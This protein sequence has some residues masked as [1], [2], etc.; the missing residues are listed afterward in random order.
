[1]NQNVSKLQS[2]LKHF[3]LHQEISYCFA[4]GSGVFEQNLASS[5]KLNQNNRIQNESRKTKMIDLVFSVKDPIKWHQANLEQN[6]SHYSGLKYLGAKRIAEF[7]ENFGGKIYYNT[8]VRIDADTVIK[9]GIISD[10]DFIND[11]LDWETLYISGRLHKPTALL[12]GPDRNDTELFHRVQNSFQTNLQSALHASFLLLSERFTE[13]QLY[14][15]IAGLS[16]S[17]DFRMWFGEDRSKVLKIVRPQVENFHKIYDP[18]ICSDRFKNLVIK[19]SGID[20]YQQD[21]SLETIR[22]HLN[23]LPKNVQLNIGERWLSENTR[24]RYRINQN[25][26]DMNDLMRTVSL[27]C[28]YRRYVRKAIE[29]IVLQSS[30]VQTI[31]GFLT[32][33]PTKSLIYSANKIEKMFKSLISTR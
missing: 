22:W 8:L 21:C 29:K 10:N 4:Y 18:I 5:N 23:L 31:K 12:K 9:Y 3:P 16:Y 28:E 26:F 17:G 2:L 14:L 32:A 30:I 19:Q 27:D 15:S 25:R 24:Q 1:M 13:E 11:L 20:C 7:Q 33:G 6:R